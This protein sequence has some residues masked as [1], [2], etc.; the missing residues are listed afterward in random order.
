M[1]I[2]KYLVASAER[3]HEKLPSVLRFLFQINVVNVFLNILVSFIIM[4]RKVNHLHFLS[5]S[6]I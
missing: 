2:G 5:C 3:S 4:Y 6:G 1:S